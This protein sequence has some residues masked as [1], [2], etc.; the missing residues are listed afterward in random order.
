MIDFGRGG[1]MKIPKKLRWEATGETLGEGG[2][3][4]VHLVTDKMGD[5]DGNWALKALKR[6]QPGQAYQ[7]FCREVDAIKRLQH[8]NIIRIVDHSSPEAEFQ[9]YVME[10]I[11]G[12][13]ALEPVLKVPETC[14]FET[15]LPCLEI[16]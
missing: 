5:F 3:A 8:P 2:Q 6:N 15:W 11:E 10:H 13:R 14:R 12:V 1:A 9:F 7:R 16:C 4:Q